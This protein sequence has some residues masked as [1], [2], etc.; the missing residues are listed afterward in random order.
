MKKYEIIANPKSGNET[1]IDKIV[2]IIENMSEDGF[3]MDLRLT[4]KS[5]DAKEFAKEDDGEDVIVLVGG[6][7]TLN[8][9]V[10]GMI[11]SGK[12]IPLAILSGGTV[13][14]FATAMQIPTEV[15]EFCNM[16]K[17][18]KIK[19]IDVGMAGNRKFINVAAGGMMTD[20]AYSVPEEKKTIF[21]RAAYYVEALKEVV[22]LGDKR[23]KTY[24]KLKVESEEYSAE[25]DVL[26]FVCANS[27]SV[28]GFEL[29]PKA[30]VDDGYIDV[31]IVKDL[32]LSELPMLIGNFTKGKHIE[33]EK[34]IYFQT[35]EVKLSTDADVTVDVDGEKAQKLP[36]T[37][38]VLEKAIKLIIK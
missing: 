19:N 22:K 32:D 4:G 37:F 38:N 18:E 11:D 25:E 20:I 36:L 17:A 24:F 14:D 3:K 28:G 23:N 33:H 10:N 16:L 2:Q 21:G 35:K 15:E 9:V 13:N 6:D 26:A 1:A 8:E 31:M 27:I 29:A 12:E 5:G 34:V 30:T 7:G